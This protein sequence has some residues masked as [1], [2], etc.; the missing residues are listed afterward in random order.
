M[1]T[2]LQKKTSHAIVSIFET[3]KPLGDYG[4]F[5]V[6]EGD[7]GHLTYGRSQT[8]LASGNLALLLHAYCE[9]DGLFSD[10]L[11]PYLPTFD[12]RDFRL[13]HNEKVKALLREAGDD[14][15]MK[16]IQDEFFDRVYWEPALKA[17]GRLEISRPL[18]VTVIYDSKIHGSFERIRELTIEQFG[19]ATD[20]GE[21]EW[22]TAY[23]FTRR[24]WLANHSNALLH[25]TVYRMD[26]F[27]EMIDTDKWDLPL[28]LTIRNVVINEEIFDINYKPP[29][30]ASAA[31]P[32]ERV[33][34]FTRPML[35]GNDVNKL[36]KALNFPEE[37]IDGIFGRETD[38]A[39]REFQRA[40]GLKVDGK[41]GPATWAELEY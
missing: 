12:R 5:S 41:S 27:K 9:A 20:V 36:Q 3:G 7:T 24:D 11:G 35:R 31:D 32:A 14:P 16:K 13:D 37:D 19:E 1:L 17:A 29:V 6:L 18:G 21:E 2:A 15:V 40:H 23:I 4:R 28:P 26:S 34:F 30:E 39:V 38:R 33:L 22:I 25:K 8:T 10:A